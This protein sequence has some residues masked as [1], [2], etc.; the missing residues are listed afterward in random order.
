MAGLMRFS[1]LK[2]KFMEI[3]PRYRDLALEIDVLPTYAI[4]AVRSLLSRPQCRPAAIW[5]AY[6]ALA[7]PA[8]LIFART[9]ATAR[10]GTLE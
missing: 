2:A 8:Q 4:A 9:P 10:R 1:V 3:V 7:L 5:C 6:R